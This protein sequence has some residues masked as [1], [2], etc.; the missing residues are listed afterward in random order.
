MYEPGKAAP[1]VFEPGTAVAH[2]HEPGMA[3]A[4]VHEKVTAAGYVHK[5]GTAAAQVPAD[6]PTAQEGTAI[7]HVCDSYPAAPAHVYEPGTVIVYVH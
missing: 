5:P 3:T 6:T 1:H 2:V 7:A 4:H